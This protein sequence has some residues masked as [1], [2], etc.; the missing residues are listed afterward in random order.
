MSHEIR[1]PLNAVLG[2]V[3]LLG[4]TKL[5]PQQRKYLNM[6]R[7]SGQSLLGILNDVLDF[8]KIE[9]R[10]LELSPVDFDLND[11]MDSLATMMTMNA[12]DKE[13]EL[14]ISV[15][16][17]CRAASRRRHA[18]AANPVNLAG[19]AIKFTEQGEVVVAVSWPT[20]AA[21]PAALRGARHRHRHDGPAAAQ[22]FNAFSQ[23]DQ[24]ITRRFGGTGLGLAISK[25][26]IHMMGG[27]IAVASSEGKGS[28]FWFSVPFECWRSRPK[29]AARR[30]WAAAPAGG[31][32]QPHQRELIAS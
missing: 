5:T 23:G 20:A 4:N 25:H 19:N 32:R 8:S 13:L 29:R 9:A 26:L 11:V 12:G 24:S 3:Y 1:T 28:R 16:P 10:K 6:V 30:R 21:G 22:L 31:R 18:P 2:M 17:T 27:E 15:G 14:A 7:V